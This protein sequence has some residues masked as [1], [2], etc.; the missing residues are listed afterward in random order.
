MGDIAAFYGRWAHVYDRIATAPGVTRWRRAAANQ[1]ADPG[2]VVVEMG[3]GSGANLPFLRE[4][5]GPDGIVVG[6][7]VTPPLLRRAR[8]RGSE[9]ENVA[10]L[11]GDATN[12]PVGRPDAI[13]ATFVC[14]LLDD[15]ASVV[16]RWCDLLGE[17]GRIALLDATPTDRL[18]GQPFNPLFRAFVAAGSPGSGV[19]DVVRAPVV[20]YG[21]SLSDHVDAS[22]AAVTERTVDREFETFAL[23]F[24]GLLSGTVE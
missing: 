23:G 2:D 9:Y 24:V 22:R 11:Q 14:G 17:G 5:V 6:I 10:V 12:P 7:D 13:L 3:C 18:S 16:A 4:R 8:K 21:R 20:G 15:P 1:V 19:K